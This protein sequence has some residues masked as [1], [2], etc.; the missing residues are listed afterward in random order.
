MYI[1][2]S[3]GNFAVNIPYSPNNHASLFSVQ[4]AFNYG[5]STTNKFSNSLTATNQND[6]SNN[7]FFSS[8]VISPG[9]NDS[10]PISPSVRISELNA[11]ADDLNSSSAGNNLTS[12][13]NAFSLQSLHTQNSSDVGRLTI[14]L[15]TKN[16][17]ILK[18]SGRIEDITRKVIN[19]K[20]HIN[21]EAGIKLRSDIQKL[22]ES[23]REL[24]IITEFVSEVDRD[25]YVQVNLFKPTK[26]RLSH[27]L[28]DPQILYNFILV[29]I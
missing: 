11:L 7:F 15:M 4:D 19:Q 9:F 5:C 3:S 28:P 26:R 12:N 25:K 14:E 6:C 18:L 27:R 29:S 20:Y 24:F 16:A 1:D 21:L 17:Q 8:H 10:L 13:K 23:K 2:F 22:E